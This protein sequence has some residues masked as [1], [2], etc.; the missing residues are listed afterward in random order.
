MVFH[1]IPSHLLEKANCVWPWPPRYTWRTRSSTTAAPGQ[2][3]DAHVSG[4]V[5]QDLADSGTT[6]QCPGWMDG[7]ME[8]WWW[9]KWEK[10]ENVRKKRR[11]ERLLRCHPMPRKA[12]S[13]HRVGGLHLKNKAASEKRAWKKDRERERGVTPSISY[14]QSDTPLGL[15]H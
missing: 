8:V 12:V 4:W 6:Q 3:G 5:R 7:W 2:Q 11:K 14:L 13:Q 10:T 9:R 15:H 1:L